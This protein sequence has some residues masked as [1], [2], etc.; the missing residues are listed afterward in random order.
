MPCHPSGFRVSITLEVA[1]LTCVRGQRVLFRGLSF[2]LPAGKALALEGPNGAGKTSLLR[3]LAAFLK[4]ASGTIRVRKD[5]EELG[6]PEERGAVIGWLAHQDAVKPQM[7]VREQLAFHARLYG[8]LQDPAVMLAPFGLTAIADLPGQY[9][10]AG[11]KRRLGLARL[12]LS[13]RPLWLLD[14]PLAALDVAG[15]KLVADAI[16]AHCA[17]GGLAVAATHEPLGI[18]CEVLRLEGRA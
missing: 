8:S 9:L 7:T 11:Q 17:A 16:T 1:D 5:G 2:V 15:K 13:A 18:A 6:D 3:M 10:S 12:H 4:P 14:E